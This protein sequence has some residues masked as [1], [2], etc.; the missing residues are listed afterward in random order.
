[1][2]AAPFAWHQRLHSSTLC[3]HAKTSWT[4]ESGTRSTRLARRDAESSD[5]IWWACTW[6]SVRK[7]RPVN[8]TRKPA[9]RADSAVPPEIGADHRQF[10]PRVERAGRNHQ[11][12]VLA[13]L[14]Q[15]GACVGWHRHLPLRRPAVLAGP[16]SA[17]TTWIPGKFHAVR[18]P[19]VNIK[20][21]PQPKPGKGK[22]RVNQSD[23]KLSG[24]QMLPQ[25]HFLARSDP[26]RHPSAVPWFY[27]E[28]CSLYFCQSRQV[29]FEM[30]LWL[31]M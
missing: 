17:A 14:Q 29:E 28:I 11:A 5:L 4:T 7:P 9:L 18:G 21:G 3:K 23:S 1:M 22:L 16:A 2:P 8:E 27:G 30:H 24:H 15:A 19:R 10:E 31:L 6:P 26:L 13:G 12:K 20:T 25:S